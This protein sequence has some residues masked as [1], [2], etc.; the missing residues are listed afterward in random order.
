MIGNQDRWQEGLFV[1][2]P[3][4]DLIPKNGLGWPV[5][6]VGQTPTKLMGKVLQQNQSLSDSGV[7]RNGG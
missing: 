2:C 1:A 7:Y 4:R 6:L 5:E 3:L